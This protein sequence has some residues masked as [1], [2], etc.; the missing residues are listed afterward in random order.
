MDRDMLAVV[1]IGL[2]SNIGNKKANCLKAVEL[3]RGAGRI[4]KVSSFYLT[5]PV[6]YTDQPDFINAAIEMSTRLTPSDLLLACKGIEA[7]MGREAGIRWGP[8]AIDID[9]LLYGDIVI[10]TP[11]LIIPHP[12][13]A[14]RRFVLVPLAEIAGSVIHPVLGKSIAELISGLRDST[15][16]EKIA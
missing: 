1:Y 14:E 10:N 15:R 13:M 8:R 3:L 5:E 12:R 6:G 16:V 9:I 7:A 11:E 2:G 4:T